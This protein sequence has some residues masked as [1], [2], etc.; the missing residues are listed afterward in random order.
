VRIERYHPLHI[1]ELASQGLQ[2]AQHLSHV[3]EACSSVPISAGPALTVRDADRIMLIGGIV[4]ASAHR[5]LLW[6]LLASDAGAHMLWL[7]RQTLKFLDAH[8]LT[9]LEASVEDAFPAGC[10]WIELLGFSYEGLM[11][12]Y[13]ENGETHRRYARVRL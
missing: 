13:G 2:S 10:R 1:A 9:R 4:L 12:G 6:A 3:S 11:L 7:H 8:P 5:G